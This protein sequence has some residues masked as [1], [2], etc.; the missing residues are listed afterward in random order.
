MAIKVQWDNPEQ[1]IIRYVYEGQ[2]SLDNFY[3]A[4][5]ESHSMVDTVPH[6]VDFIIDMRN[7]KLVPNGVL[8]H[9]KNVAMRKHPRQGRS[10]VVG[11]SVF[12]RTL[13]DVY[14]KVYRSGFDEGAFGFAATLDEA[15]NVIKSEP[16]ANS[17]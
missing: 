9:G 4:L 13:F 11:A 15:Y 14:R 7:S 16:I 2:W 1:T 5:E 10:I 12:V 17:A 8:S 6:T 3:Q